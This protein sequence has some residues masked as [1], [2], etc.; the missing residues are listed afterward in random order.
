RL[1]KEPPR[2]LG[3]VEGALD[4]GRV[5]AHRL[6]AEDVLPALDRADRPLAVH[7]VRERDVD[8]LD[9]GVIEQRLVGTVRP[10]DAPLAPLALRAAPVA[11]RDCEQVDL[12]RGV[13][14]RDHLPVDVGGRDDSPANWSLGH[15]TSSVR[16]AGYRR[17]KRAYPSW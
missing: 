17:R 12:V 2:P 16:T 14:A 4:F 6:L 5:A 7:R 1:R 10:L 3:G 11:T 8:R 9:V 15:G 13:S